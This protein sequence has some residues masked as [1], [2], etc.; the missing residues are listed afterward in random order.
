MDQRR[1]YIGDLIGVTHIP[2]RDRAR[3]VH[4]HTCPDGMRV[5]VVARRYAVT[6]AVLHKW[7]VNGHYVG[8]NSVCTPIEVSPSWLVVDAE[9]P[10]QTGVAA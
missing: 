7:F 10:A 8:C 9:H 2:P 4:E 1:D 3:W 6:G 5:R